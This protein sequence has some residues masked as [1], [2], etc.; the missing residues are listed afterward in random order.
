VPSGILRDFINVL[1][2][3]VFQILQILRRTLGLFPEQTTLGPAQQ[4]NGAGKGMMAW[5]GFFL[6]K[7]PLQLQKLQIAVQVVEYHARLLSEKVSSREDTNPRFRLS[8]K[9]KALLSQ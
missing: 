2:K 1:D 3:N 7:R 9:Q 4:E 6:V 5:V 8:Q